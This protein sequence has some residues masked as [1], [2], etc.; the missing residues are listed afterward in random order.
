[1]KKSILVA[2]AV[3]GAVSAHADNTYPYNFSVRVGV[4]FP[5]ENSYSNI[6][7]SFAGVGLEYAFEK[8]FVAGGESY[9]SLD[10]QGKD[11]GRS[12]GTVMPLCLNQKWY[13]GTQEYGTRTYYFVGVGAAFVDYNGTE[14][15]VA[16]RLGVGKEFNQNFFGEVTLM[17]ADKASNIQ[18]NSVSA[19]VGWRF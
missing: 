2:L 12:N 10:Y 18:P 5:I 13:T 3:V 9:L 6:S 7:D 16:A 19:Y 1:M 8:S 15:A 11:F 14:A 4:V 17:L